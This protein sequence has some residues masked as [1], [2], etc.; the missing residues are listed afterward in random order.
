MILSTAD[1]LDL[2]WS[3]G[4]FLLS[5]ALSASL[6]SFSE[7]YQERSLKDRQIAQQ[8]LTEARAQL[9]AAQNDQE[10]MAAY[11]LEYNALAEQ[12]V[13]GNEQRLDWI[14][15]LEKLRQQGSVLDLKYSIAPQQGYTPNPALDA[16]NFQLSR[17]SM[18]LQ[19]DLLHEEQLLRLL[20][21]MHTQ[22]KGWFMLDGCTLSRADANNAASLLKAECTGGWLT[23]KAR[24]A[25]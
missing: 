14:E 23:M 4:A 13:I 19:M 17:S 16:G 20:N 25:P 18:T 2:K 10:N 8:Q 12:K 9:G 7:K 11:A 1:L 24:N 22:M 15:G 21:A 3:L 6:V 5:L